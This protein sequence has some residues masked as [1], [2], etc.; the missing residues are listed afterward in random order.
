ME[1][2]IKI[3]M[4]LT[5]EERRMLLEMWKAEARRGEVH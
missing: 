4:E 1:E 3:I 2:L 5:D